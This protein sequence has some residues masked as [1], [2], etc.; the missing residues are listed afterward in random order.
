MVTKAFEGTDQGF[1]TDM[2]SGD[3]RKVVVEG[4]GKT[5]QADLFAHGKLQEL[6]SE[7]K[8]QEIPKVLTGDTSTASGPDM[9]KDYNFKYK[10]MDLEDVI[11]SHTTAMAPNPKYTS[12]LQPRVRDRAASRLQVEKI[13]KGLKPKALLV[14]V[15]AL[16][17]GPMIIGPDNMV[18]SGNGRT[19]ALKIAAQEHPENYAEYR[20][21]LIQRAK[22]YGFDPDQISLMKQPILVRERTSKVSRTSFVAEA[23]QMA[24]MAMSPYEQA[25]Q[26][27][28]SIKDH[29]LAEL[30]VSE[31]QS[32]DQALLSA[33]NR[34]LVREFTN[35]LA[36]NERAAVQDDK[37]SLNQSGLQ[38]MKAALFAK[39]Y[40]GEAGRRL[41][42]AFFESLEPTIKNIENG[43]FASL[44]SIAK[45]QGLIKAGDR[46]SDLSISGDISKSVDMLARLKATGMEPE[47]YVKQSAM[48][49]RE[50][51]PTQ[52]QLLLFLHSVGRSPKKVRE[53]AQ[54]YGERVEKSPHPQQS[55]MFGAGDRV[56]KEDILGQLTGQTF[57]KDSGDRGNGT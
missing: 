38:R 49:D 23:N 45:S 43:L 9:D 31:N 5:R 21:A 2:F 18:E 33:A 35:S 42:K 26:D 20:A 44:P 15:E 1:E 29:T 7:A 10:I 4:R 40:P 16:D 14:D 46:Y 27:A 8:K 25:I 56:K 47:K 48:F 12:E 3:T 30:T 22:K 28:K 13:A 32:I 19:I 34:P 11:A 6:R 36:D 41:T 51:T 37:G 17:R 24:V 50:L 39:T 52:E 53:F 54:E 57:K 55:T